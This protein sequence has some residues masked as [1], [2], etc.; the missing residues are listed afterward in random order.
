MTPG[1]KVAAR[2]QR[3]AGV[4]ENPLG[5]NTG[6]PYPNQWELKWGMGVGWPWCGAYADAMYDEAGV[7][8]D[9]IGHPSTA[10]MYERAK[11]QGAIVKRAIP[12]AFILWPGKH[13]GIV[14]RDLGNNTAYT[15]EGNSGDGVRY[16]TRAYGPGTGAVI[17]AP[18]AIRIGHKPTIPERDYYLGDDNAK[19]RTVGPWRSR[20]K[21]EK[22]LA[23]VKGHIR[24]Y[25]SGGKFYAQIGTPKVYG[26]WETK[27]QRDEAQ[28][29]LEDRL[30]R[31]LRAFSR[32]RKSA[33]AQADDLG[34]TT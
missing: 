17:V 26:P 25:R 27:R 24:R 12:G 5:S 21:R 19:P 10:V 3:Y 4:E 6:K 30:G 22:A 1:E 14:V 20:E 15:I 18:R 2:A 8:D 28:A 23:N 29:I 7:D 16:R 13:V 11:A 9:G 31:R 32:P 34:K 33:A